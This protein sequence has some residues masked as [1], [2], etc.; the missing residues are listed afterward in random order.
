MRLRRAI[1]TMAL[2]AASTTT[3]DASA[4][5]GFYV[6][7]AG[8]DLYNKATMVV[9]MREGT[10]TVL[11][12]Q[13]AYE[14]PPENFAMVVPVPAVLQEEDVHTLPSALFAK[15]DRL[16]APRLVEYWEQD[17]CRPPMPEPTMMRSSVAYDSAETPEEESAGDLGVTV[18]AE[19]AVAEY[20]IVILSAS[21]SSGLDT[22]L[23]REGYHI[24]EGAEP[25]L[26]PY[27]EAGTKFFVARVDASRIERWEDGRA[28]LSPLRVQYESEQFMLP[29]R[30]GLVNSAGTQDLI[31]HILARGQRYEVANY[32]NVTIP[33]NISVND[34]VRTRFGTF[35]AALFDRLIEEHANA[36]VTE[37]SWDAGSCDPCPGPTLDP[38]DLTSLG[39]DVV[40]GD[41][42]GFTLTRLHYRYTSSALGDD[43]VFRPAEPIVGG[44]GMPDVEGNL[45]REVSTTSINNFQGRYAILHPWEGEVACDNPQ[46]GI[47]GGPP[48]GGEPPAAPA[49][50]LAFAERNAPLSSFLA[51]DLPELDVQTSEGSTVRSNPGEGSRIPTGSGG[52][53]SC[54]VGTGTL[55]ASGI[56]LLLVLGAVIAGRLRGRLR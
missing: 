5:C 53:A 52:C 44:R 4:F 20:D 19:F 18:E 46:P 12:M 45:S 29:V 22:W 42:Y 25:V 40:G 55:P 49:T 38:S 11:S 39:L 37:Y 23:R 2:L 7:G 21:D 1:F 15:I 31:V 13:N 10:R 6:G 26:R 50:N 36:V 24:P 30:L 51:E 27:V 8:A 33:T 17:P 56:A 34:G 47:W 14:G 32:D 28:L 43:L 48:S 54:A 9:L 41:P 16:A 35:Y 3:S